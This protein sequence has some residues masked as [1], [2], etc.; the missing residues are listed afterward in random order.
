M[1]AARTVT[2]KGQAASRTAGP[3]PGP[4]R[5]AS[6]TMIVKIKQLISCGIHMIMKNHFDAWR[7]VLAGM[8]AATAGERAS[9]LV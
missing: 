6:R 5:T 1:A 2:T 9:F 4:G 3:A 7:A 8:A